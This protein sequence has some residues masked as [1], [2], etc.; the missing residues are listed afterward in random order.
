MTNQVGDRRPG[1]AHIA[2]LLAL[3]LFV[4]ACGTSSTDTSTTSPATTVPDDAVQATTT[5][6]TAPEDTYDGLPVGFTEDGYPYLGD[7]DAPV[8][9]VEFSDYL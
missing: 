5:T 9:L 1:A 2:G 6:T 8:S 4:S 7:P 3:A